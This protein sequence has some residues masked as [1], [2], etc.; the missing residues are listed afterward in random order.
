MR[1]SVVTLAL[2]LAAF[3]IL[4]LLEVVTPW[5]AAGQPPAAERFDEVVRAQKPLKSGPALT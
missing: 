2:L 1:P 5:L 3:A 4:A